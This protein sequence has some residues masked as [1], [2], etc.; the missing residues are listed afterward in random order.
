MTFW[1]FG[2]SFP[3][4][5]AFWGPLQNILQRTFS[6]KTFSVKTLVKTFWDLNPKQFCGPSFLSFWPFGC[7]FSFHFAI[8]VAFFRNILVFWW[9]LSFHFGFLGALTKHFTKDIFAQNLFGQNFG[10]NFLGPE[11]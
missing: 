10:Q 2:G 5:L 1:P 11:P 3:F 8:L 4:I 9:L 6:L 7:P